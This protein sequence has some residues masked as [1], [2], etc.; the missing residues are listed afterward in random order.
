M[1]SRSIRIHSNAHGSQRRTSYFPT[2]NDDF[3]KYLRT[4]VFIYIDD[5][6]ITSETAEQHLVDIDEV[7]GKIELTGMKLKAS[8]CEFARDEIKIFG[9]V[10]KQ[11]RNKTKPG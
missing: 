1:L 5:L 10:T 7:L 3:K 8:K 9:F 6:I 11:R 4:R 2:N